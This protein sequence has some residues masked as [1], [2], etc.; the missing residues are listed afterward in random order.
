[1]Q[2][3]VTPLLPAAVADWLAALPFHTQLAYRPAW[4]DLLSFTGKQPAEITPEDVARWLADLHTRPISGVRRGKRDWS[5]RGY[6]AATIAQWCA[7]IHSYYAARPGQPNPMQAVRRPRVSG[8]RRARFLSAEQ[9]RALLRAMRGQAVRDRRNYALCLLLVTTGRRCSEVCRLRWGD[10]HCEG[11]RVLWRRG[12]RGAADADR[13]APA[14]W[15]AIR[16]HL[17]AEG[18]LEGIGPGDYVF[19]GGGFPPQRHPADGHHPLSEREAARVLKHRAARAGLDPRLVT[20]STLRYTAAQLR[21]E[22]GDSVHGISALL[23]ITPATTSALLRQTAEAG[24]D[25][26][27]RVEALLGI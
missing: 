24:P 27:A 8:Y 19:A 16:E 18:R 3:T 11:E 26:W 20:P 7:A 22:A 21:R 4:R 1:M 13:L 15:Q 12:G 17:A 14:A 25:A 5:R 9:T 2:E 23:G 6:A 10:L